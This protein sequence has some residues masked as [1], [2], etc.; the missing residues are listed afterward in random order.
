MT[1][2]VN[3]HHQPVCSISCR[4]SYTAWRKGYTS[5]TWSPGAEAALGWKQRREARIRAT[6]ER[7]ISRGEVF[8]EHGSSCHICGDRIKPSLR[9]PHPLAGTVDHVVPLALGG[10]HVIENLR[11]AHFSCN[12]R[13]G[14]KA[15]TT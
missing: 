4:S 10:R 9:V 7:P 5:S 3:G 1:R 8:R 13:K 12:A 2:K 11:P 15:D 6:A 14:A